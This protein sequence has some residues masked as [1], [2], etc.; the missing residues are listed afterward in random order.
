MQQVTSAVC[1]PPTRFSLNK[2]TNIAIILVLY[3]TAHRL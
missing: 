2:Q 1:A 3:T